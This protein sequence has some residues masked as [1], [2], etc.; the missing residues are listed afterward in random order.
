MRKIILFI[1]MSL[2]GYIADADGRVDWLTEQESEAEDSRSDIRDNEH[3][4]ELGG[5]QYDTEEDTDPYEKFIK[6]VDTIIMGFKTYHQV[7]TDLSPGQW[8]YTEQKTYVIT[9]RTDLLKKGDSS[10]EFTGENPYDLVNRL[11]HKSGKNI[12]ICGGANVIQQLIEKD[13]IDEYYISVIPIIL[14]DGIR[15]FEKNTTRIPLKLVRTGNYNGIAE[16]IYVR[17][18]DSL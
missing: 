10:V 9:H 17:R 18:H 11:K 14:G 7:A 16:L 8:P 3:F 2:D 5:S 13:C 4:S 12:W 1:A 15:L 6:N